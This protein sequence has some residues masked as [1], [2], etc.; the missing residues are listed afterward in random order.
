[1]VHPLSIV[2]IDFKKF[3]PFCVNSQNDICFT[4]NS[5]ELIMIDSERNITRRVAILPLISDVAF[6]NHNANI[7]YISDTQNDTVHVWNLKLRFPAEAPCEKSRFTI[8]RP[9]KIFVSGEHI[10]LT[11]SPDLAYSDLRHYEISEIKY[12]NCI[13]IMQ[14]DNPATTQKEIK[15]DDWLKPSGLYVDDYDHIYTTAYKLNPNKAIIKTCLF[16]LDFD[17]IK[18]KEIV[19]ENLNYINH[20]LIFDSKLII[21]GEDKFKG[22]KVCSLRYSARESED[23]QSQNNSE[24][25]LNDN[26]SV[27]SN[28][29][30]VTNKTFK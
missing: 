5:N 10:F 28:F 6:D 12:G 30:S 13:Y 21:S 9:F 16:I 27:Q 15:F 2:H 25:S 19:L 7:L 23:F 17:G 29:S 3:G 24:I 26:K 4:D 8:I 1:M 20:V 22:F 18:L 11:G 14:K